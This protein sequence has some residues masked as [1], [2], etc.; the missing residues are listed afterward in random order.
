MLSKLCH[1]PLAPPIEVFN[2]SHLCRMCTAKNK[3]DLAPGVKYLYKQ[4]LIY[5]HHFAAYRSEDGQPWV[6]PVV[7]AA[8]QILANDA[9]LNHEYLPMLGY[10]PFCEAA[11]ALL[12]GDDSIA[13]KE[14]RV[15]LCVNCSISTTVRLSVFN[16]YLAR[17]H[18]ALVQ[19]FFHACWDAI[20]FI[21]QIQ[22]GVCL[23]YKLLTSVNFIFR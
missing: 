20:Q 23:I 4:K 3:V 22:R 7:H 15:C 12:L 5:T 9:T 2:V 21:S 11:V 10:E 13:I 18:Y 14:K 16:V 19:N 17:V 1:V 8:E 6:L